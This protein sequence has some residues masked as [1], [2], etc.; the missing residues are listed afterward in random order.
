MLNFIYYFFL[1]IM[2]NLKNLLCIYFFYQNISF[3]HVL[4]ASRASQLSQGSARA[5]KDVPE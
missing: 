3:I 1:E 2:Y 5:S 4:T